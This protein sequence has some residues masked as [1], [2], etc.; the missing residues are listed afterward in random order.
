[1]LL[2]AAEAKVACCVCNFQQRREWPAVMVLYFCGRGEGGLQR[3]YG[4]S[5]VMALWCVDGGVV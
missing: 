2:Y 1:M 4:A 3:L 5:M